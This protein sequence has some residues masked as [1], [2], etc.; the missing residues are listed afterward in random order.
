[1]IYWSFITPPDEYL[2]TD[3]GDRFASMVHTILHFFDETR[4]SRTLRIPK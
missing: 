2:K 4:W 1:V 3:P